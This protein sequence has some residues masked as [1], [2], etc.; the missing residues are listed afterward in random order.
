MDNFCVIENKTL[1]I[2]YRSIS[3]KTEHFKL[4][5]YNNKKNNIVS[6]RLQ[7][8]I[9]YKYLTDVSVVVTITF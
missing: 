4:L 1:L 9:Y 2:V 8:L 7:L 6:G 5:N 3:P